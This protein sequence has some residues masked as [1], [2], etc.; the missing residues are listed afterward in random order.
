MEILAPLTTAPEGSVTRPWMLPVE[1]VVCADSVKVREQITRH[2]N[3]ETAA[4]RLT[5]FGS[6]D[7]LRN[8]LRLKTPLT[9]NIEH[10]PFTMFVPPLVPEL[11]IESLPGQRCLQADAGLDCQNSLG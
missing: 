6:N 3:S 10:F 8:D 11:R 7:L 9:G 4:R 5:D 1:I 2:N